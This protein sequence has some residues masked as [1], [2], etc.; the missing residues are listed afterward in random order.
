M[1]NDYNK[2]SA[3]AIVWAALHK[4]REV[5]L[6]DRTGGGVHTK[7]DSTHEEHWNSICEAM[8]ILKERQ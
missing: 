8:A 3:L 7:N 1:N 6:E 5:T 4:Y 2:N